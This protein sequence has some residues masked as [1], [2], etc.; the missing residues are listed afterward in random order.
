MWR[1][2]CA[3]AAARAVTVLVAGCGSTTTKTVTVA[4]APPVTTTSASSTSSTGVFDSGSTGTTA[5]SQ[6]ASTDADTLLAEL[7]TAWDADNSGGG[8]NSILT[9][10]AV[11]NYVDGKFKPVTG[12]ANVRKLILDLLNTNGK[13]N[14]LALTDIKL[15]SDGLGSY[16]TGTG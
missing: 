15:G 2:N 12:F 16:A 14:K 6:V 4:K 8:L 5:A 9:F 1:S 10:N 13:G 11:F 3:R 7:Q